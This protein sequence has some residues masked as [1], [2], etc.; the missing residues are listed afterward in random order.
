MEAGGLD[1]V[2]HAM[3]PQDPDLVNGSDNNSINKNMNFMSRD[4]K[5]YTAIAGVTRKN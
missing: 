4:Y 2:A 5:K 1:T 3:T